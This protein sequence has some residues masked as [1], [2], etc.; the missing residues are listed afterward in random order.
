MVSSE[1]GSYFDFGVFAGTGSYFDLVSPG[2]GSYFDLLS[3][4]TG[5]YFGSLGD[6]FYSLKFSKN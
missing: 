5:S 1:T 6:I 4:G 2:T 3:P